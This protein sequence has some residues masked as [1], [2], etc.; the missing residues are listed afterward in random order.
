L[1]CNTSSF[2]PIRMLSRV[3]MV[4]DCAHA[5]HCRPIWRRANLFAVGAVCPRLILKWCP[6]S[7]ARS[8]RAPLSLEEKH[9]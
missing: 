2:K 4:R 3:D 8:G 7:A 5:D 6:F 9:G 1:L